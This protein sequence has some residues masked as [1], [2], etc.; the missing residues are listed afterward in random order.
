MSAGLFATVGR[1]A[2]HAKYRE[3]SDGDL[4]LAMRAQAQSRATVETLANMKN[5][6]VYARQANIAQG[7]Q[8]VNNGVVNHGVARPRLPQAPPTKLLEAH[9]ERMD[10]GEASEATGGYPAVEAVGEVTGPRTPAGKVRVSRN[11]DRGGQ[12]Q[13]WR[14]FAHE[15]RG[16]LKA[17][18]QMLDAAL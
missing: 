14:A 9:G 4:R 10:R 8:Q 17:Q 2:H 3:Q 1:R 6:P 13:R 16:L 18:R 5:P 7:P 12:R 15:L 11:G